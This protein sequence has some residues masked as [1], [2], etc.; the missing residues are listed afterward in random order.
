VSSGFYYFFIFLLIMDKKI[1][2]NA[3]IAE[4]VT[5]RL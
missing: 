1:A 2:F 4:I 3:P 5:R